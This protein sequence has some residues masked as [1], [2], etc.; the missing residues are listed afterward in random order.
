MSEGGYRT[1][2]IAV[3]AKLIKQMST[4]TAQ[5]KRVLQTLLEMRE[6]ERSYF[7]YLCTLEMDEELAD[8]IVKMQH[9]FSQTFEQD[10]PKVP[11]NLK[12][13]WIRRVYE[14]RFKV[15]KHFIDTYREELDEAHS[16]P[17]ELSEAHS[18]REELSEAHSDRED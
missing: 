8:E 15:W 3:D 17:E 1:Y 14:E 6:K 10:F 5:Q 4:A 18:D 13:R 16:D 7:D 11:D 9:E 12:C 2:N